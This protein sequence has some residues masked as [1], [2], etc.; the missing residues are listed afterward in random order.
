MISFKECKQE[1]LD[2]SESIDMD[3][4][5]RYYR[6]Q[7]VIEEVISESDEVGFEGWMSRTIQSILNTRCQKICNSEEGGYLVFNLPE[8]FHHSDEFTTWLHARGDKKACRKDVVQIVYDLNTDQF[9]VT[10]Y[11]ITMNPTGIV[12]KPCKLTL[13]S[14]THK[15]YR[16]IWE[17]VENDLYDIIKKKMMSSEL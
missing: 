15:L 3:R 7:G 9:Y 16:L 11:Y 5:A 14:K 8:K 4:L 1:A 10:K 17:Y 13:C 2:V 6:K 12:S